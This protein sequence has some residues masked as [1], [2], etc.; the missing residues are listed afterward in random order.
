MV[1]D[2]FIL[3]ID[4]VLFC[5][6]LYYPF[7]PIAFIVCMFVFFSGKNNDFDFLFFLF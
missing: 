2:H 5:Q 1:I 6:L 4:L 3:Y 7:I